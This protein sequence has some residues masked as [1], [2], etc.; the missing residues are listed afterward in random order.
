MTEHDPRTASTERDKH[1]M[2]LA[3][4]ERR[5]SFEL[6]DRRWDAREQLRDWIWLAVMIVAYCAWTLF[7][8]LLEPGLR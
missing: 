4:D 8:F 3:E 7:A 5:R 6:E 1:D 2:P